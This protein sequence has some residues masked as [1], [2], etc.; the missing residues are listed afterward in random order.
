MTF[1]I[2]ATDP[3][4]IK[5]LAIAAGASS[6]LKLRSRDGELGWG[7][8]SQCPKKRNLYYSVTATQC[9]C[10]DSKRHGLNRARIGETGMHGVCKHILAVRLFEEL[11]RAQQPKPPTPRRGTVLTMVRHD[12]DEVSWERATDIERAKRYDAIF[13][14]DPTFEPLSEMEPYP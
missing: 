6:W 8:P 5:A 14:K 3:R 4:T 2:D 13:G 7:I 12:D 10:Q 11:E 9:D 1:V